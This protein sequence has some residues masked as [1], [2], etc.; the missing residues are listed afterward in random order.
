MGAGPAGLLGHHALVLGGQGVVPALI[1]IPSME[2][3]TALVNPAKHLTVKMKSCY[4]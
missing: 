3:N 1:P 4:T 2:D